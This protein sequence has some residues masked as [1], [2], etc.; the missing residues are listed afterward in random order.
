MKN[1]EMCIF[2]DVKL[3]DPIGDVIHIQLKSSSFY[4][5]YPYW[6]ILSIMID[7]EIHKKI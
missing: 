7:N 6:Y 5:L 2:K 4:H 1:F 3:Y